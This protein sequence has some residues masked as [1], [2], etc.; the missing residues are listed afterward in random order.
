MQPGQASLEPDDR[1]VAQ[2]L[3]E[4]GH[5]T[6]AALEEPTESSDA[7]LEYLE[8]QVGRKLRSRGAIDEFLDDLTSGRRKERAAGTRRG[9]LRGALLL[10]L[11][12]AAY[13]H[14]YYWDVK[15]VI[16]STPV[17]Q[18]FVPVDYDRLR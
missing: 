12:L 18:V 5:R 10:A 15:L 13:F 8:S 2:W 4:V 6:R 9:I 16:A 1:A 11:A 17:V 14:Y 7:V 3:S